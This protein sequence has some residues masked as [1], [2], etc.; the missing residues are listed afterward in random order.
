MRVFVVLQARS[1]SNTSIR[2][3]YHLQGANY[4]AYNYRLD[5]SHYIG[6]DVRD[7]YTDTGI[8][9]ADQG[10]GLYSSRIQLLLSGGDISE[11]ICSEVVK[12]VRYSNCV[13]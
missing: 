7:L 5:Y 1:F 11:D 2:R 3:A 6:C 12:P 8:E 10:S 13:E 4:T 9:R